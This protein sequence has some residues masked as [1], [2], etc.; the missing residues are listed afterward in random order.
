[1]PYLLLHAH[2]RGFALEQGAESVP[3]IMQSA[4]PQPGLQEHR[5]KVATVEVVGIQNRTLRRLKHKLVEDV[6]LALQH[7]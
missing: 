5:L 3:E 1:M 6:V 2:D 7:W 4:L